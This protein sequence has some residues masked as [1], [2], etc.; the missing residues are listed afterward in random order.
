M[1]ICPSCNRKITLWR[2]HPLIASNVKFFVICK[3]GAQLKAKHWFFI[4]I[5]MAIIG[6]LIF[7][8]FSSIDISVSFIVGFFLFYVIFFLPFVLNFVKFEKI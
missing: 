3:C 1:A 6:I 7:W 8:L 4:N 2:L 5:F